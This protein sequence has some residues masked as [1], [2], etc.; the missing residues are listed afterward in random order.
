MYQECGIN[1][2]DPQSRKPLDNLVE[3]ECSNSELTATIIEYKYDELELD[4]PEILKNLDASNMGLQKSE[5]L[6]DS[7][8]ESENI[9]ERNASALKVLYPESPERREK[10]VIEK[11]GSA[12]EDARL[13]IASLQASTLSSRNVNIETVTV[14]SSITKRI[15]NDNT[16]K[17]E[18]VI[19][20]INPDSSL[21]NNQY[22]DLAGRS[23]ENSG[24]IEVLLS[25]QECSESDADSTI[26]R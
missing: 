14:H 5:N 7:T 21:D 4:G 1:D 12:I 8:T 15:T 16:D 17:I 13:S 26:T 10:T 19:S 22:H 11:M 23:R 9:D 25:V 3:K 2:V 20:V 6:K 18:Q 24:D